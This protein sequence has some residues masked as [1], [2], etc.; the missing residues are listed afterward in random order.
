[1]AHPHSSIVQQTMV[2]NALALDTLGGRTALIVNSAFNGITATFLMFRLRYFLQYVARTADDDGPLLVGVA[3]GDATLAE[4]QNALLEA[5]TA[6]PGDTSQMLTQDETWSV[7]QNTV[8]V[9]NR[10]GGDPTERFVDTAWIGFGGK[11]GI[12]AIE[13]TGFQLFVFNA[14]SGALATGSSINGL[15]QVQGRWLRD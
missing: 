14:G 5:N 13:G 7:Y 10:S 4:I 8:T 11:N 6:G 3:R 1:M 2:V 9:F 12:P 15:V